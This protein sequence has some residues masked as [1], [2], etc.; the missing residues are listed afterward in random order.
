VLLLVQ[1]RSGGAEG[2]DGGTFEQ[3]VAGAIDVFEQAGDQSGLA[4]A[5]RLRGWEA[6]AACRFGDCADAFSRALELARDARD[7]RQ[8]R[9]AATGYGVAASLGPTNVDDAIARCEW[10]IEQTAGDRQSEGNLLALLGGLYAMQGAFDH[11]RTLVARGRAL[12][13]ELDLD[14]EVARIDL[15]AWRVEML[16]GNLD[17]AERKARKAYEL[18]EAYGEKYLLSTVAGSLA[19]TLLQRNG[20]L[21]E[22][23]RLT[24]QT[25]ALATEADVGTQALWRCV[26]GRILAERGSF[27][28]AEALVREGLTVLEP[29]DAV[30][31]QLDAYLDLGEVLSMAGDTVGARVAY[32]AALRLAERKGGV[33]AFETIGRRLGALDAAP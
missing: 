1:L 20:S 10:C 29:T 5:W 4:M 16:S 14:V 25:R 12:L 17:A 21:D 30:L 28:E 26:K 18:L 27:A 9:R 19:Q 8:E 32:D 2:W 31:L 24:E 15:E 7:V 11:A 6:G 23:E 33:V 3:E 13:E 22:A